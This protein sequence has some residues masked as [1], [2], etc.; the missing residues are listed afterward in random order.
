M[1][2]FSGVLI[3][4]SAFAIP[5]CS[6]AQKEVQNV[7]SDQHQ[8]PHLNKQAKTYQLIVDDK[9]LYPKSGLWISFYLVH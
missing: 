1:K 3:F 7:Y 2:K 9:T 6:Y 4:I 5:I 8:I